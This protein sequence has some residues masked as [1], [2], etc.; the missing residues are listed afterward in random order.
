MY[1]RERLYFV[2]KLQLLLTL[3]KRK[4]QFM[5]VSFNKNKFCYDKNQTNTAKYTADDSANKKIEKQNNVQKLSP[6]QVTQLLEKQIANAEK[7]LKSK[8]DHLVKILEKLG[9][10]TFTQI[11]PVGPNIA[12]KIMPGNPHVEGYA[13]LLNAPMPPKGS[14]SPVEGVKILEGRLNDLQQAL[15]DIDNDI[16]EATLKLLDNFKTFR[17]VD[18]GESKFIY[19]AKEEKS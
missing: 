13:Q 8:L 11:I 3:T 19:S 12:P 1:T 15:K 10:P 4:E 17:D 2:G 7:Q 14:V 18:T 6:E 9:E 5:S 16:R